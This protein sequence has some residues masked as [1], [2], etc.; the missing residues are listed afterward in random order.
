MDRWTDGWIWIEALLL[1]GLIDGWMDGL[2]D[3]WMDAC[4]GGKMDT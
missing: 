1:Y 3:A 4:I 2:M